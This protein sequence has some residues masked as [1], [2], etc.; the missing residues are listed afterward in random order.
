MAKWAC[1]HPYVSSVSRR[2]SEASGGS[3]DADGVGGGAVARLAHRD[4]ANAGHD[5]ALQLMQVAHDAL[6][7]PFGLEICVLG[8][9]LGLDGSGE[10]PPP[11]PTEGS[12]SD[13]QPRG[14]PPVAVPI[15][16]KRKVL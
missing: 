6:A 13:L 2:I 8:E 10:H 7:A 5:L 16:S 12:E 14:N 1:C 9:E 11:L 4:Q 3:A 15:H